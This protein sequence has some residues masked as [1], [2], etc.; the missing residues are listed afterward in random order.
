MK[1][2]VQTIT[3][4][5]T[6]NLITAG[7]ALAQTVPTPVEPPVAPTPPSPP[8]IEAVE[9]AAK[10]VQK[11][12]EG[13][14][15]QMEIV[16]Q[17]LRRAFSYSGAGTVLV[18]P[19][20]EMKAED[21]ATII[22]DMTVMAR[23]IDKQLGQEQSTHMWFS[24]D[25]L[26][27]SSRMAETMYLQGYGALFLKKVDF[28]LSPQTTVQEEEKETQKDDVDPVWEQMRREIYEPQEDRR[29]RTEREEEKYDAEKVENL[30]INLIKA[31]KHAA[32]LRNLKPD[33]SV[34]LTI[35]GSGDSSN[36]ATIAIAGNSR[37]IV[38]DKKTTGMRIVTPTLP[39]QLGS[40]L[41]SVL[42]IRAKKS[43]VDAFAKGNL[44]LD[45]FRQRVQI[46]TQ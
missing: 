17:N 36:F 14:R 5:V 41:P 29:R 27:H 40:S 2:L 35:T 25:F 23:I 33:E 34:I 1:A 7:F 32:N 46:F 13:V 43:D 3:V 44:D 37:V 6:F 38:Q 4:L 26:G 8:H 9:I 30:K 42:I 21:L 19:T 45:K 18:I 31:L 20:S 28:P 39:N 22:E 10:E 12:A 24:G 16:H 11:Q 15:K